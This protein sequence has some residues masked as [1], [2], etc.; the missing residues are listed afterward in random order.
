MNNAQFNERVNELWAQT[1]AGNLPRPSRFGAIE[2]LTEEYY[3]ANGKM[4]DAGALDRLA[5]LCLYE[6]VTDD[7]PWKTQNTEYPIHS[8]EQQKV[9]EKNEAMITPPDGAGKPTRRKRSDYENT[10]AN[11]VKSR[12]IERKKAYREFTKVQPV[13]HWNAQTGEIYS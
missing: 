12:N 8:E 5:T 6:E 4:P 7:T 2:A 13:K 11:K 10:V 3:A 9:I 1:K